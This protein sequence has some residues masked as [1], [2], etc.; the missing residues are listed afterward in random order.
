MT[1]KQW[2]HFLILSSALLLAPRALA[3]EY[4]SG[5][6]LKGTRWETSY[7]VQ[8]SKLPG[9]TVM[10]VGGVHGNEP[11]GARAADQIRHWPIKKG[12][13]IVVSRA[14]QPALKA[15]QRY[16]TR[17]KRAL[18]DLNRNFPGSKE[19][20]GSGARGQI[21]QAIWGLLRAQKAS[22]LFDLHEGYDF[23]I[24]QPKSVGSSVI[25]YPTERGRSI[26]RAMVETINKSI[27]RKSRKFDLLRMPIDTSLARAAGE[28]LGIHAMI[29]ETT[30]KSQRLTYRVR[31]HRVVMREAL[32][33]LGVIGKKITAD[34]I[35]PPNSN[36]LQV[37]I[38]DSSGSDAKGVVN[39][40]RE[41]E[42]ANNTAVTNL[43]AT[44]IRSGCL[45][46]FS[47]VIFTGGSGS[48][49]AKALGGEG[50]ER[51]QAFV[52]KGGGYI[53]IC[54]GSYLACSNFTWGLKIIDARTV[55]P[56]WRRGLANVKI[57][58][59]DSGRAIFGDKRELLS[60]RYNNGP[61]LTR[62][63]HDSI[64]DYKVLAWF[65]TE[66][67]KNKTPKGVM[68]NSPAIIMGQFGQGKVICISPHPE[69]TKGLQYFISKALKHVQ[70]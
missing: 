52:K 49:Q 68:V 51:V 58:L 61:I 39:V 20:K 67:S 46:Q 38:Y 42:K 44:D 10:I 9:P 69:A 60:V 4:S 56:K 36:K 66:V 15:G 65:R 5:V 12:T 59:S 28:H 33:K 26:A 48:K 17:V 19:A 27:R 35:V 32:F 6:L 37:A 23:H 70:P 22:W 34:S 8:K 64:P 30:T 1:T 57:E 43:C 50:R 29:V 47:V 24:S 45:K 40:S 53:G 18:R 62:A 3:N 16:S 14:N 31:Q 25:P 63:E 55:S 11:A 7:T 2:T 21:A 13:V 41:L 54:A